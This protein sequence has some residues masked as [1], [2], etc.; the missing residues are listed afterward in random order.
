VGIV[1]PSIATATPDS[2][3]TVIDIRFLV[4]RDKTI[5]ASA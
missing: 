3:W 4:R 2:D 1:P 5:A